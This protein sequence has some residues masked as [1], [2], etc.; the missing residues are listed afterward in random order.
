MRNVHAYLGHFKQFIL[1]SASMPGTHQCWDEMLSRCGWADFTRTGRAQPLVLAHQL[2]R[3]NLSYQVCAR[4]EN[5]SDAKTLVDL[6]KNAFGEANI[7]HLRS[8]VVSCF[9]KKQVEA[10]TKA[11]KTAGLDAAVGI[12]GSMP[13]NE[14]LEKFEQLDKGIVPAIVCNGACQ[15]GVN[16]LTLRL[17]ILF[18]EGLSIS[19][20]VQ[21]SGRVQRVGASQHSCVVL[22][23]PYGYERKARK[24]TCFES[25]LTEI[26][27]RKIGILSLY[28]GMLNGKCIRNLLAISN[29][30]A[31]LECCGECSNCAQGT[32]IP[33]M[34]QA[35][36]LAVPEAAPRVAKETSA[37]AQE[38]GETVV[39]NEG[40]A[41]ATI[42][43]TAVR[44]MDD[45]EASPESNP[46]YTI[47]PFGCWTHMEHLLQPGLFVTSTGIDCFISR[48]RDKY[49]H[50]KIHAPGRLRCAERWR[51]RSLELGRQGGI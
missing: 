23:P 35:A 39:E 21:R 42:D 50:V 48:L 37:A 10:C 16:S 7:K 6:L 30:K 33:W 47:A 15:E 8:L 26:F 25:K 11:L 20:V 1:L 28:K 36:T 9:S 19:D 44:D 29:P 4:Q 22:I 41:A 18:T 12:T 17:L 13:G 43:L 31:K 40:D 14:R 5:T 24:F 38:H 32:L 34:K 46:M 51:W 2:Q 3:K 45:D 49:S 27:D